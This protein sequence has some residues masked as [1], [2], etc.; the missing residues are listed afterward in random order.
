MKFSNKEVYLRLLPE[1]LPEKPFSILD[2]RIKT[3]K[4]VIKYLRSNYFKHFVQFSSLNNNTELKSIIKG[5]WYVFLIE[6]IDKDS[7][8][9]L[10]AKKINPDTFILNKIKLFKTFSA[11][12][13]LYDFHE[14]L[15]QTLLSTKVNN[16]KCGSIV[17]LSHYGKDLLS[18]LIFLQFTDHQLGMTMLYNVTKFNNIQLS[19]KYLKADKKNNNKKHYSKKYSNKIVYDFFKR[20]A[21]GH[22]IKVILSDLRIKYPLNKHLQ[23]VSPKS[24]SRAMYYRLP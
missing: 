7:M 17:A 12:K 24:F 23:S 6:G 21:L 10:F 2:L 9:A 15:K 19:D 4:L 5:L 16:S 20:K 14:W 1:N 8:N 22:S 18:E 3:D 13:L 11:K